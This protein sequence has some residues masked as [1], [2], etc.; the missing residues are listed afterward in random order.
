MG[1]GENLI[2]VDNI[3]KHFPVT[4][5]VFN[6]TIY[7][8]KAVNGVTFDIRKGETFGLVGETGCGKTTTSFCILRLY[9]KIT[10]GRVLYEGEDI[11][12]FSGRKM[13][14][15]RQHMQ[16]I[17]E[18]PYYALNPRMTVE[19][20]IGEPLRV[21]NLASGQEYYDRIAEILT[22]V[23]ID[24]L[25][26]KRLPDEFSGGER[27]RI[28]IARAIA[29][30]P[31]FVICDNAVG[32]LDITI[33]TQIINLLMRI[34]EE[35]NMTYLFIAHDLAMVRNVSDRVAVM[36]LGRLMEM[37]DTDELFENPMNPYTQALISAVP[38]PDPKSEQQRMVIILP[39][40][41]LSNIDLPTGCFFHPRCNR[42]MD[43]CR[44]IAPEFTKK[45]TNHWVACHRV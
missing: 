5:G 26:A 23:G 36:Y 1:T 17:F 22:L 24:P 41:I 10:S 19:E 8:I 7:Y 28:G 35:F 31:G 18:N 45:K 30:K 15:L 14:Q 25:A 32:Q 9:N 29:A 33:Q 37:A 2:E 21:H 43:V 4:G 27:Q 42:A 11:Y 6:R 40:Y 38:I 16:Y 12:K 3:Y 13:R 39:D 34:K 20:L 44:E